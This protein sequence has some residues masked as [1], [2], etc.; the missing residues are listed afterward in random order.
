MEEATGIPVSYH[1]EDIWGGRKR[2]VFTPIKRNTKVLNDFEK[3]L[4]NG[5]PVDLRI[6]NP[7]GEL[8]KT[9]QENFSNLIE[10]GKKSQNS[11]K[12]ICYQPL[13]EE[14][15]KYQKKVDK[16][17]QK[18]IANPLGSS[19]SNF[20]TNLIIGGAVSLVVIGLATFLIIKNGKKTVG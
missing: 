2:G 8:E 9:S 17:E 3:V 10:E 1:E 16:Q 20:P 6:K 19:H 11:P 5:Q 14:N 7:N 15:K 13:N 18:P 4:G 12:Q